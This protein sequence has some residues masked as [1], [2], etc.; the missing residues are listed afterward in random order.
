MTPFP[1]PLP[2]LHQLRQPGH[3]LGGAGA[4]YDVHEEVR[5][6]AAAQQ[7]ADLVGL[8]KESSG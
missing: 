3:G 8:R 6:A 5:V 4:P 7:V 1:Q 2:V